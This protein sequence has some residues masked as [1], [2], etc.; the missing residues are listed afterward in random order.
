MS[1]PRDLT[2]AFAA[3]AFIG[4]AMTALDEWT[5][6]TRF[7]QGYCCG[8]E[9]DILP[10]YVN[11]VW[12]AAVAACVGALVALS[13]AA[14]TTV[15]GR[16]VACLA[17]VA[18][19]AVGLPLLAAF[20]LV[21]P[22]AGGVV[23]VSSVLAAHACGLALGAA[24]ALLVELTPARRT[25]IPFGIAVA[26]GIYYLIQLTNA[27]F[28]APLQNLPG[29]IGLRRSDLS[30]GLVMLMLGGFLFGAV[31]AFGGD[32]L[33]HQRWRTGRAW[34]S[35]IVGLIGLAVLIWG[36]AE[37]TRIPGGPPLVGVPASFSLVYAG[38]GLGIAAVARRRDT[39]W[40]GLA[41]AACGGLIL[42]AAAVRVAL[43]VGPELSG[44][45]ALEASA[46]GIGL[47]IAVAAVGGALIAS[48]PQVAVWSRD[49]GA[50][51][52]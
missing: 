50:R 43:A 40:L 29:G 2:A 34:S 33:P 25:A 1:R 31:A 47:G 45:G 12:S 49:T 15:A 11:V 30:L 51:Q 17:A 41:G 21:S 20:T 13:P 37:L 26:S 42:L 3:G 35:L 36:C 10:A 48:M 39:N 16:A 14:R 24:V 9:R 28:H 46:Y 8:Y 4:A 7:H 44:D 19:G 52:P 18:G 32:W 27:V 6:V 22:E 5:G 38:I 23:T